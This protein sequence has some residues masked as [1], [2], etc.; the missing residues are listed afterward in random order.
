MRK[1]IKNNKVHLL[2]LLGLI[3]LNL[4]FF[5]FNLNNFFLSD[6]FDWLNIT[7]NTKSLGD[8]FTGNYYGISGEGGAYRPIV[9]LVFW[10]NYKISGLNPLPFHLFSLVFHIGVC[11]LIYLLCLLIFEDSKEKNRIAI[12]A[13]VIFS[14][15]PNHSEPVIWIAAIGDPIC[16]FFYVLSLYLYLLFRK[17]NRL[18]FIIFS[19]LSFII[20]LL[21]KE[22][23]VTL[24]LLILV[25]EIFSCH[26]KKKL[27]MK[28][29][30]LDILPFWLLSF[31]YFIVRY[32]VIGLFFGYYARNTFIFNAS[33]IYKMIIS[34]ITDLFFYGKIR[35]C[36]TDYFFINPLFFILLFILLFVLIFYFLKENKRQ[37]VFLLVSYFILI[38]P[39]IFLAM[40]NLS[41]EG[42]RYNYLPSV[43]FCILLSLILWQIKSD[44]YLR[45]LIYIAL[46]I[47]FAF[48]LIN[49]NQT[50]AIASQITQ[51]IV[52]HDFPQVVDIN[53]DNE[54][55]LFISLPDKIE[56]AQVFGNGI[57]QA[58]NLYYPNY[59][60]DAQLAMAYVLISRQNYNKQ[61]LK[62][63]TYPTGG[64][65]AKTVDGK[66]WTTGYDRRETEDYV[67]ELWNYNYNNYTSDTI[68]LIIKNDIFKI[69]IYNNGQLEILNK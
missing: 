30:F 10:I 15:L 57:K 23:A 62:W 38:L 9:N 52:L 25:F 13:S 56:G 11:Y 47:Y 12:L 61:I 1:F 46:A 24:P 64:Y 3:I 5:G 8:Y 32:R 17:N 44:K 33:K 48:F 26:E 59:K 22:M 19:L 16:A 49:K 18:Y 43:V 42:E 50:W 69:L 37:A 35:V 14:I 39:V 60:L 21:A 55:L 27:K 68:R 29:L 6:D 54:K 36:L 28:S 20:A 51:K 65:I 31:S 67:F 2:V 63:T 4:V 7:K 34:L 41:D 58:I 53:K 40:N 45:N 66:F